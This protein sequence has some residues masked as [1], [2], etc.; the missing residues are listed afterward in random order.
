SL[1]ETL[2]EIQALVPAIKQGWDS[3]RVLRL[4]VER[5]WITAG[6]LAE[7]YRQAAGLE[8][9]RDPWA[10]LAAYRHRLAH[11]LPDDLSPDR[12]WTDTTVDLPRILSELC[13]LLG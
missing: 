3:D 1:V 11:G 9:G 6:N 8:V 4:A 13:R 12:V 10:E 7:E 2:Q 5:L